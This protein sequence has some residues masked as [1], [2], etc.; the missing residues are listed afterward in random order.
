MEHTGQGGMKQSGQPS[1]CYC[2][3]A[4]KLKH[5]WKKWCMKKNIDVQFL[6]R[7]V[8]QT[9]RL[10]TFKVYKPLY[11]IPTHFV[12]CFS[13]YYKTLYSCLHM[14]VVLRSFLIASH[15]V[16]PMSF[17]PGKHGLEANSVMFLVC[18]FRKINQVLCI[19][20]RSFLWQLYST[21]LWR[22]LVDYLK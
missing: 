6:H 11:Y 20:L 17:E 3:V 7:L 5:L 8:K 21:L 22:C 15:I 4:S 13:F 18:D 10:S 2:P 16:S 14:H 19:L 12:L 9:Q 1:C